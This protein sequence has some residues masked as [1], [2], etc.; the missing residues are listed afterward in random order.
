MAQRSRERRR[1]RPPKSAATN[2][3]ERILEAALDAFAERGYAATSVRQIGE[4]VGVSAAAIYAHFEGKQAILDELVARG[5]PLAVQRALDAL[6]PASTDDPRAVIEALAG[7]IIDAWDE[8]V[9]RR[10]FSLFLREGGF[11]ADAGASSI[12][13][14]IDHV[15]TRLASL[16]EHWQRNG[17]LRCIASAEEL[18]W[19]LVA[20]LTQIR[21]HCLH[22]SATP[23]LR[24]EGRARAERHVAFFLAAALPEPPPPRR[25]TKP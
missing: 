9:A 2:T 13:A 6:S 20:P 4:R 15:I 17:R 19:E 24:R 18:A 23:A 25:R 1:G 11:E 21:M 3:R 12:R 14:G 5:G 16:L 10:L 8:P 22:G 7:Q